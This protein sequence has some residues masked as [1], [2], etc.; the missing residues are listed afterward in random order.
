M[1]ASPRL[2]IIGRGTSGRAAERLGRLA[3][4]EVTVVEDGDGEAA[5]RQVAA[6]DL[7]VTSPGVK[8]WSP[9]YR[10]ALD[11]RAEFIGEMEFGFRHFPGKVVA[12]T[13]TD[14][15]TTTTEL[16]CHLLRVLGLHPAEA[17][18]IGVPLSAIA[19]DLREGLLPPDTVAVVETSSFQLERIDRFAPEA[20]VLLNIGSDHLDRYHGSP[21]EYEAVKRRIFRHVTPGNRIFGISMNEPDARRRVVTDGDRILLDGQEI[22]RFSETRL[23]GAH[24]LENLIA[25][26][27][28]CARLLPAE[29]FATAAFRD[30]ATTFSTGRHRIETVAEHNGVRYINDS[31][32]TNPH[33][34]AAALRTL[35]APPH[36]VH[37]LLGGLD[38]GMDFRELRTFAEQ[39]RCAYLFGECR[40]KIRNALSDV[41][42]CV[43]FG[44]DFEGAVQ[45][46]A[47]AARPGETVL[48]APACA[49][50]DMFRNYQERGDRFRAAVLVKIS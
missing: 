49:S 19:A 17:G 22:L 9:L 7:V 37:W 41:I 6:A 34:A 28:L 14:G 40:E 47:Q 2:I 30:G 50:M 38:K 44:R 43:D 45:A 29:A 15:K 26:I 4:Y 5:A 35:A 1:P 23:S 18:N 48:L 12:I 24:N 36:S 8:P 39:I 10:A 21:A 16:T 27:E 20:A 13:G 25:A 31:K 3:G 32:A 42:E 11:G 33:A 46:A